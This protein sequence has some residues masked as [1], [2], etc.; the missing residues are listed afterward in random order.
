MSEQLTNQAL[1]GQMGKPFVASNGKPHA[2]YA[3]AYISLTPVLQKQK[4][5]WLLATNV[6]T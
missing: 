2:S 1:E 6:E 4:A 3:T 5:N